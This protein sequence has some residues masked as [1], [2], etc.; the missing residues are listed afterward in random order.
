MVVDQPVEQALQLPPLLDGDR[1]GAGGQRGR[2]LG[3]PRQHRLP[4]R[5]GGGDLGQYLA[6][7]RHEAIEG[8]LPD[9]PRHLDVQPR[10]GAPAA[11]ADE[12]SLAVALDVE[13][14]VDQELHLVPL[15]VELG[16]DGVDDERAVVGDH[17]KHGVAG[18]PAVGLDAGREA[19]DEDLAGLPGAGE[20]KVAED[21]APHVVGVPGGQILGQ[22]VAVVEVD[23]LGRVD[24]RGVEVGSGFGQ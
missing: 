17:L 14:R 10:L 1:L 8:V 13:L 4:V 6:Q 19:R 7:P 15:P 2:D 3:G 11:E 5:D 16:G 22:D 18:G 23:Q 12:R 24:R 9:D 20:G 21:A